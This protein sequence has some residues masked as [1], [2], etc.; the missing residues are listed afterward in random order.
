MNFNNKLEYSSTR[1]R[2]K[3]TEKVDYVFFFHETTDRL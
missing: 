2:K 3:P 1:V